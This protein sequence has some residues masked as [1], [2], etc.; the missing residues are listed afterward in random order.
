[1]AATIDP[2]AKFGRSRSLPRR[3][4]TQPRSTAILAVGLLVGACDGGCSGTQS[5]TT[6][7][8]PIE[9]IPSP[10]IDDELEISLA[11][12][13]SAKGA[14]YAP[15]TRHK[16]ADGTPK[17]TNRL[18]RESSPY[19]LQH[20]H[21]PV[22]W[23]SWGD[24]AFKMARE[25]GRPIFLSV[26]YSTCHW[27]HVMEEESFEDEE[28][29]NYINAHYIPIKVDREER[30]D[31]DSIYMTAVHVMAGRG[32]WP[33]SV[34]LTP[35]LE[36][37]FGGTYFPP[38]DGARGRAKGFLTILTEQHDEFQSGG[39]IADKARKLAAKIKS[40]LKPSEPAG[41]A[42]A[43][44]LTRAVSSAASRYDHRN[45]GA[46]GAPKFPSSFPIALLLRHYRTTK[47]QGSL[48]MATDT[49][50]QMAGGGM[51][52]QI[53]GG[54]HRYSTDARWL[55]PHF[56]KMLYD[57]ALL[58]P[59]YL[60]AYQITGDTNFRRI[61]TETL[62][63][64]LRDMTSPQGG[65][66][67]ATDADSIGPKGHREEGYF[68][69]WT[70]AELE[71]TLGAEDAQ[72]LGGFYGVRKRGNF[73]GRTILNTAFSRAQFS[74]KKNI[75]VESLAA[76]IDRARPKLLTKRN[77][78]A[79]PLRDDKVQVSW[80]GLMITALSR[81][82]LVLGKPEYRRAARRAADFI[83]SDLRPGG[84]LHHTHIGGKAS[85]SAFLEDYSFFASALLDLFE[86]TSEP[87]Y[88][89]EAIALMDELEK[90][91]VDSANGGYYLTPTGGEILL[92][93]EKPAF[94]KAIPGGNSYA[95]MTLLRLHEFTT[96]DRFRERAEMTLRAFSSALKRR[97]TA[98][99]QMLLAVDFHVDTPKEIVIVLPESEGPATASDDLLKAFSMTFIPNRVFV[100][101]KQSEI[102]AKIKKLI[103]WAEG[104]PARDEKPT[105]YVC[106]QGSCE[107]PT[108]SAAEFRRQLN[109]VRPP[110]G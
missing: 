51:Y 87:R 104:K 36:P 71:Q 44:T 23:F 3:G 13:L 47:A 72:L 85:Q 8:I 10:D 70:P 55:V 9:P 11:K 41:I 96:D 59:S 4:N 46:R 105:A 19:L 54:F 80:N 42:G 69:T 101:A 52:D 79:Q 65:F 18:I 60:E 68:F 40:A 15:R 49:H 73:E 2:L 28:I 45:G 75:S 1:M 77:E 58:V 48:D 33:M 38:R 91:F 110:K 37:F 16:N 61:A 27:C 88:L 107:L 63:Y 25:T 109:I 57:N 29:A 76:A 83:L 81:G 93:R 102:S 7:T 92:A 12:E 86:V 90:S 17:Y 24:E 31:V 108:T 35:E 98:L 62:D 34:W 14:S 56:E 39:G 43:E 100:R 66:Y 50:T 30:P 99:D 89:R 67:S 84:R 95:L 21:N 6:T 20:A 64:V 26:G 22:N 106:E 97:P 74:Q 53:G 103:P 82:A 94:D 32:G 5:T 78:R